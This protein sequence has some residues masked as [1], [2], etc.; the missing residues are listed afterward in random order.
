MKL[1]KK[2]L[3][4]KISDLITDDEL[5]VSVLEDLEDSI[6]DGE[7]ETNEEEKK[8][9]EDLKIKY[10]DL[11]ERYKQRFLRGEEEADTEVKEEKEDELEEKEVIDVKE[12]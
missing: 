5:K 1:A 2:E 8:A 3:K 7:V 6:V 4:Q 11:L 10:D 12:I 9:Y